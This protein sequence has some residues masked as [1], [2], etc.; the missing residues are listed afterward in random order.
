MKLDWII[1]AS[2]MILVLKVM[3]E[4]TKEFMKNYD[5]DEETAER[6]VELRDEGLDDDDAAELAEEGV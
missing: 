6:A 2:L 3:D 4:E 1:F 5:L